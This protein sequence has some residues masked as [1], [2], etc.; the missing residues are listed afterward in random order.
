MTRPIV[1][2]KTPF[3]ERVR[4]ALDVDVKKLSTICGADLT[5]LE[6]ALR[7]G[8]KSSLGEDD[9][10][11]ERLIAYINERIG[12]GLAIRMELYSKLQSDRE[13]RMLRRQRIQSR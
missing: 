2:A 12:M 9:E 1:N 6:T 8:S 11:Y 13:A 10:C 5:D 3:L 4:I 7:S